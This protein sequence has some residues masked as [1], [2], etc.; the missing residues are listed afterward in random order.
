MISWIIFVYRRSLMMKQDL[1]DDITFTGDKLRV[2]P[3]QV[4][5]LFEETC[6]KI[7]NHLEDIFGKPE[8]TGTETILMVGGFSESTMLQHYI[9]TNFPDKR[10]IIPEEAGLAV[11]KGAVIFG[12]NPKAI[13]SRVTK[14]TY[15]IRMYR[16]F[17]RRKHPESRKVILDGKEK[18]EGCFDIH[19]P[20]DTEVRVGEVFGEKSYWPKT[21]SST[22]LAVKVFTSDKV[23]PKYTDESGCSYLGMLSVKLPMIDNYNDRNVLVKL[24]YGDTELGVEAK[25]VKTGEILKATLNFLG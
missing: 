12:H 11:L 16:S 23:N 5:L 25:I 7:V 2:Q 6:N 4:E 17:D 13:A 21:R 1:K 9:K 14:Y 8:V 22:A 15:G 10:V 20:I 24:K 18:C 3:R 19:V